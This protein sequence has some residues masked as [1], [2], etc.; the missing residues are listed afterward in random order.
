VFAEP[1]DL[2]PGVEGSGG[3]GILLAPAPGLLGLYLRST[4]DG[5]AEAGC[6]VA[7]D[8]TGP[9]SV[10]A[11]ASLS[12]SPPGAAGEAWLRGD[13]PYVGGL[14][15]HGASRITLRVPGLSAVL[16][17]GGSWQELGLPGMFAHA[18]LSLGSGRGGLE[19]LLGVATP[20]YRDLRGR[21]AADNAVAASRLRVQTTEARLDCR[22]QIEVGRPPPIRGAWLPTK[23]SAAFSLSRVLWGSP[24]LELC[25]EAE[26]CRSCAASGVRVCEGS[27]SFA[28]RLAGGSL[29][30][31]A[32]VRIEDGPGGTLFASAEADDRL[33]GELRLV[34]IG[35]RPRGSCSLTL[36]W[37]RAGSSL[38]LRVESFAVATGGVPD[39]H[40]SASLAWHAGR[41]DAAV[42]VT[43]P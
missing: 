17:C 9:L 20:E 28:V 8:R 22:Y 25:F 7:S 38:E 34:G 42:S 10:E 5:A 31:E 37:P 2:R 14:L 32:G 26:K 30:A 16:S 13:P 1:T 12:R 39:G 19:L 27:G 24:S 43:G 40:L 6:L 4:A 18:A 33:R 35:S 11:L 36:R 3:E 41:R 29:S 15:V 21:V 23:E